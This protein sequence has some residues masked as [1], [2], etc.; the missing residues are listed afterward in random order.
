MMYNHSMAASEEAER[1]LS[2]DFWDLSVICTGGDDRT[3]IYYKSCV[4]NRVRKLGS[5]TH[6]KFTS[7]PH[8]DPKLLF[9]DTVYNFAGY[10]RLWWDLLNKDGPEETHYTKLKFAPTW[11]NSREPNV[12]W[13]SNWWFHYGVSPFSMD[14]N[15]YEVYCRRSC[16]DCN[17][18][19]GE[20]FHY[21]CDTV[22][23]ITELE[24]KMTHPILKSYMQM[25]YQWLVMTKI[26]HQI[27]LNKPMI[28]RRIYTKAWDDEF[29]PLRY[30]GIKIL[31]DPAESASTSTSGPR[32]PHS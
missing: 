17:A 25:H 5:Y 4:I 19:Y 13:L 24:Y 18:K 32:E 14:P 3:K 22:G 10:E 15:Y 23:K 9:P 20:C 30:P 27:V 16:D 7:W 31:Y 12:P 26:K 21:P 2:Q 11:I 29:Y 28:V 8:D 1:S 6:G